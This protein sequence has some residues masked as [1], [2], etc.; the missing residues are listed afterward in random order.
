MAACKQCTSSFEITDEDRKL[1][2]KLSPIINGK[3]QTI[4][5]PTLCFDCRQQRRLAWR[6]ERYMYKRKCDFSGEEIISM[7]PPN[8]PFKVYKQDVWWSD[9]W[10]ALDFGRDFDFN[11]PF[12]E[13]F[14]ELQ[15]EVP[16]IALVNNQSEN[17]EYT[18]HAANNKNCYLSSVIFDCEDIYYTD[19]AIGNC[20][21]CVDCSYMLEGC[22]LC[23][24]VYY[25]WGSYQ[26]FYCDFIKRCKNT[27]FCYDCINCEDCF[28]SWNL[29]N[30]KYCI[31]NKQYSKEEYKAE[32]AKIFPLS[33]AEL[34][35]YHQEY[36]KSKE[37]I[38]I[39]PAIYSIQATESTGDLLFNTKNCYDCFDIIDMEDCRRCIDATCLKDSMDIYHIGWSELMYECHAINNGFNCLFCHFTYDNKNAIYCDCTQNSNYLFGCAGL[40]QKRYCILN[41]QYSKEEYEELV[42]KII[43]HMKKTG[44]WGEFFPIAFSPFGY[45]QTRAQE[46]Y[47]LTKEEAISKG[48][49]WSDYQAPKPQVNKI[50][51]ASKLPELIEDVPDDILN[52]AI[53]CEVTNRPFK[54][55]KPELD[56]YRQVGLPIP[57]R[58]PDQRYE[59]R[60]TTRNPRKL[61]K[62]K[63]DKCNKAVETSYAPDRKAIIY[64]EECYLKEVY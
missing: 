39:H 20:K 18:N 11:R 53:E 19:F 2:N 33:S 17:S 59:D 31:R 46:Y 29:R 13:Q 38:A 10:N 54:I 25:A 48:I 3:K 61:W 32:M 44:E 9:K 45:N 34:K 63:C 51:P 16:R 26:A 50:I 8:S 52:W 14:R 4:S 41:K 27:W 21:D 28:M 23:Y 24:E 7:Y 58:H 1:L 15:L 22:E 64:C 5:E 6:N 56:F 49:P 40:N 55:I 62:R 47:L 60:I 36:L 12:L 30:K 35:K 42:P 43:E 57:K 37:E